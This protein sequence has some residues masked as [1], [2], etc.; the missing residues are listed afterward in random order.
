[1]N[2]SNNLS[3]K[4]S[5]LFLEVENLNMLFKIRGTL[6]QALNNISFKVNKGDF[7]GII[8]ESGSGKSTTG[9]CIIRLNQ[10]T[11]GRIE[12]DNHLLSN[13]RLSRRTNKWLR[14]N[15]QMIF[16]DPMAS[17]NPTKNILQIISE[18]LIISKII[19]K[20]TYD[21]F[22][23]INKVSQYFHYNFIV[24]QAELSYEFKQNYLK[25]FTNI[26]SSF[27]MKLKKTIDE[28]KYK[29]YNDQHNLLLS[30][31]D[32]LVN[33]VQNLVSSIYDYVDSYKQIIQNNFINYDE[34]KFE[35]VDLDLDNS[36]KNLNLRKKELK[37]SLDGLN[38]LNEIKQI[39]SEIKNLKIQMDET[40]KHKNY[41]YIKS[42][43]S[44]VLSKIKFLKQNV[45]SSKNFVDE[46]YF[47]LNLVLSKHTLSFV[48]LLKNNIYLDENYITTTINNVN[49]YLTN[50]YSPL[51][52]YYIGKNQS[53]DNTL[54]VQEK[55]L[56]IKNLKAV[57]NFARFNYLTFKNNQSLSYQ[58]YIFNIDKIFDNNLKNEE[59]YTLLSSHDYFNKFEK[60]I[61]ELNSIVNSS[62]NIS[63]ET[64]KVFNTQI[65]NK[66]NILI[67]MNAEYKKEI[68][69]H[70][71]DLQ[72]HKRDVY[73]D[74]VT[75]AKNDLKNAEKERKSKIDFFLNNYWIK[76][77]DK[78]KENLKNLKKLNLEL[79]KEFIE[80]KQLFK[81]TTN[82]LKHIAH[83]EKKKFVSNVVGEFKLRIKT[84]NAI[85]FEYKTATKETWYY[86]QLYTWKPWFTWFLYFVF[87]HLIKRDSVYKALESVGLKREHA[88]RYPHEFSGGQRQRIVIARALITE[89]KLII[90]DEPISALDV[91]IQAQIINILKELAEKNQITVLFIA[92]DL[93]MVNY[94][95]NRAIIMHQGRILEQGNVDSIFSNPIHPY[96]KSLIRATPK[97]SR[98]HVN[99]SSFDEKLNY[100]KDW[101]LTNQPKFIQIN[102]S[103][104]HFVFGTS[105][106]VEE[107][108]KQNW[109][110][111]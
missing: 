22:L 8:G 86:K 111:D 58:E 33:E 3:N 38:K 9:K 56:I 45:R 52:D 28:N 94:V 46:I 65:K 13:K 109:S 53:F 82:H 76:F 77:V 81:Y 72:K 54:N 60:I 64:F 87:V 39:K 5:R 101:S 25:K 90:A 106:Q 31:Y 29:S 78:N 80:F 100:E 6:F 104:D 89:P 91:S 43:E 85:H 92:H 105:S 102:N 30:H 4:S 96:T 26:I 12:V 2:S 57:L 34:K 24:K 99:L 61:K 74:N 42:W 49:E 93:S 18:P 37:Y 55:L 7:F 69:K 21:Y 51:I 88:Y 32:D 70:H 19:Y 107:W 27:N 68:K 73:F 10:P 16:Q 40:Y 63:S 71:F 97:L 62:K 36:K 15:V 47:Q 17:L 44:T 110:I 11:G 95:C 66:K 67:E 41:G 50:L 35:K 75:L 83:K 98:V 79:K 1:M 108:T 48:K 84:L 20:N 14:K 59:I 23:K 103:N